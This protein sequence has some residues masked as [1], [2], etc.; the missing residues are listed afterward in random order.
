MT[1]CPECNTPGDPLTE[2]PRCGFFIPLAVSPKSKD[3]A[4]LE[5]LRAQ[6][7]VARSQ[8]KSDREYIAELRLYLLDATAFLIQASDA[9]ILN[10]EETAPLIAKYSAIVA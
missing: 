4:E 9:G 5:S 1:T 7:S 10:A 6:L 3:D 2:C 8:T